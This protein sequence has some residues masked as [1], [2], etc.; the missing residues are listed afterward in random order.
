MSK[1][2]AS[3]TLMYNR[4]DCGCGWSCR[5]KNDI[6]AR[7]KLSELHQKV[8]P[9]KEKEKEVFQMKTSITSEK[10]KKFGYIQGNTNYTDKIA[11]QIREAIES[12]D[13]EKLG[14]LQNLCGI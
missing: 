8:C 5:I 7:N 14:Q 11:K 2:A 6:K 1:S 13:Y 12:Q 3:K 9:N 4:A 10:N